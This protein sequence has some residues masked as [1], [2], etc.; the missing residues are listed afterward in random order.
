MVKWTSTTRARGLL[1]L[2]ALALASLGGVTPTFAATDPGTQVWQAGGSNMGECSA[3]LG[4]MQ[5]RDDVNALIRQYG[6]LLGV[7]S[8]GELYRVRA[9]QQVN[10]PPA[11]EC[12]Q[13]HF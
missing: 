13:H 7:S 6:D 5:V 4:G 11:Q 10:L 3:Y 12:L 2:G 1:G 8:P 9:Q